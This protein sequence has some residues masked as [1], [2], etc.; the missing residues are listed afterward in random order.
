MAVQSIGLPGSGGNIA[1]VDAANNLKVNLPTTS[2]GFAPS[3]GPGFAAMLCEADPGSISGQRYLIPPEADD[4]FRLRVGEDNLI[5]TEAWAGA[6]ISAN[7]WKLTASTMQAS[8]SGGYARVNSANSN[9]TGNVAR[10]ETLRTFA[11]YQSFPLYVEFDMQVTAKAIVGNVWE[12]GLFLS[13]AGTGSVTDGAFIRMNAAGEF[14]LVS[15]YN[16]AETQSAP[17]DIS[18]FDVNANYACLISISTDELELWIDGVLYAKVMTPAGVTG[19][20]QS[21]ALPFAI[22]NMNTGAPITPVQLLVGPVTI[23]YGGMNNAPDFRDRCALSEQGSYQ[24]QSGVAGAQTA[25]WT[26]STAP[27]TATLSNATG[28]YA[29]YGGKFLF[30]APAGSETDYLLFAFQVPVESLSTPSMNRNLIIRGVRIHAGSVGAT[31]ATTPTVLEWAIA[32]GSNAQSLAT[33]DVTSTTSIL[34]GPRRKALGMQGFVVG[35]LAG[36][37]AMPVIAEFPDSALVAEPGSWVQVI[38]RVPYGTATG[39]QLIRGSV[40]ID[41]QYE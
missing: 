6:T 15:S 21:S 27:A 31:V 39:G 24:T 36:T 13:N 11:A 37:V 1:D 18:G 9:A 25:N 23:S 38:V 34:K 19:F 22:R 20:T 7:A 8:A 26:N 30:A 35:A 16:G 5:F 14:R 28:G 10:L 2:E 12:I 3:F 17:I 29:T 4:D 33:A 40:D 41:G 32:V